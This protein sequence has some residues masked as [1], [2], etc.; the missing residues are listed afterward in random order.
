MLLNIISSLLFVVSMSTIA[1]ADKLIGWVDVDDMKESQINRSM[2]V[3]GRLICLQMDDGKPIKR[4]GTV[5]NDGECRNGEGEETSSYS[6]LYK[7]NDAKTKW[8]DL[9]DAETIGIGD[10]NLGARICK[11]T[12]YEDLDNAWRD[13][14]Y[15]EEGVCRTF[16][17]GEKRD[18]ESFERLKYR[19]EPMVSDKT[20]K[21]IENSIVKFAPTLIF[22][23]DE[24]FFPTTPWLFLK[25]TAEGNDDGPSLRFTEDT[26][27]DDIAFGDKDKTRAYINVKIENEYIDIQYW[28][29]FA[30]NAAWLEYSDVHA[31]RS[32]GLFMDAIGLHIDS[33]DKYDLAKYEA[34]VHEGDWEHI[35]VRINRD[36]K[37]QE[38]YLEAHGD[39]EWYDRDEIEWGD[40]NYGIR[41]YVA[42]DSHGFYPT[43]DQRITFDQSASVG[44]RGFDDTSVTD[45]W[46]NMERKCDILAVQKYANYQGIENKYWDIS[47][48][49]DIKKPQWMEYTGRWGRKLDGDT[50][51]IFK[52]DISG[53]DRDIILAKIA[54]FDRHNLLHHKRQVLSS[55]ET[56]K[57]GNLL[58]NES[59][60]VIWI[61][62]LDI[63]RGLTNLMGQLSSSGP[64][65]P[66]VKP[67]W[68]SRGDT[69][70]W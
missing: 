70:H 7:T 22:H 44:Y 59:G 61:R 30:Y 52:R 34:G 14:G 32:N 17:K 10:N 16:R 11:G 66:W 31:A 19:F 53:L 24:A 20:K 65:P 43:S 2:K 25:N 18:Q 1:M 49:F 23:E 62:N 15:V 28:V 55:W 3:G 12:D 42:R 69:K 68:T 47:D 46:E 64:E 51:Y 37:F 54:A 50:D 27:H 63:E 33:V 26:W 45:K 4:F 8:G 57:D 39:G 5:N 21:T 13:L 56:D 9:E 40:T 58:T 38:A 60:E 67:H 6:L 35:T 29:F 48:Q 36:G 41:V